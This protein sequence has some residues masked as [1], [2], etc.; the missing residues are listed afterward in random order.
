MKN[1]DAELGAM[2][3]SDTCAQE[4]V[5]SF[6]PNPRPDSRRRPSNTPLILGLFKYALTLIGARLSRKQLIQ[7]QG[8]SDYLRVGQWMKSRN[9]VFS[10]RA[11]NR[12]AVFREIADRVA[13]RKVLYLEFGVG[14]GRSM[15]WWSEALKSPEAVLHGFDSFQGLPEEGGPWYKGQFDTGGQ[16]PV[17][18][19]SRVKFFKGWFEQVL[20]TY[21]VGPHEVLVV[22]LDADLYSSTIYVLRWLRPHLKPGAFVYFDEMNHM[23]HEPR[24]FDEFLNESGIQFKPV[25]AHRTL[26]YVAFECVG[27]CPERA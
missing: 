5:P 26:A 8:M 7:V 14:M 11:A 2:I 21:T 20:P 16:M 9:F 17:I 4:R 23:D 13:S 24:A 27:G 3:W 6:R 22:N 25:A 19:D 15:R 1:S 12:H 18:G 10:K